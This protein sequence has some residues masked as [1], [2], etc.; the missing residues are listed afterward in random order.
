[1]E[2]FFGDSDGLELT[3]H[4]Q[5]LDAKRESGRA[6]VGPRA[7]IISMVRGGKT[8]LIRQLKSKGRK[9]SGVHCIHLDDL[10]V[11]HNVWLKASSAFKNLKKELGLYIFFER[12]RD[13]DLAVSSTLVGSS[14]YLYLLYC[15]YISTVL[16][17]YSYYIAT[18]PVI[19]NQRHMNLAG[20]HI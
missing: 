4:D 18:L 7:D 14:I 16:L 20:A 1:M 19:P 13:L 11:P 15:Y 6:K 9:G 2:N 10:D 5:Q 8:A 12:F 3:Y 17:L